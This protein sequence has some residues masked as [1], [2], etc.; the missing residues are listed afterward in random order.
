VPDMTYVKTLESRLANLEK[1]VA[2][3]DS[4]NQCLEKKVSQNDSLLREN[5]CFRQCLLDELSR[6]HKAIV[7]LQGDFHK[8]KADHELLK[9]SFIRAHAKITR[10]QEQIIQTNQEIAVLQRATEFNKHRNEA[11]RRR[12]DDMNEKVTAYVSLVCGVDIQ[13]VA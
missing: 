12:L 13:S 5:I 8:L 10:L 9:G 6:R 1:K 3:Q 4:R 7:Q 2:Q 11:L